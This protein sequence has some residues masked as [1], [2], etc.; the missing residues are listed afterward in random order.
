MNRGVGNCENGSGHIQ[1][2]QLEPSF[3]RWMNLSSSVSWEQVAC[4]LMNWGGQL[5]RALW[6]GG[7]PLPV[8]ISSTQRLSPTQSLTGK[9]TVGA[10]SRG[11][12]SQILERAFQGGIIWQPPHWTCFSTWRKNILSMFVFPDQNQPLTSRATSVVQKLHLCF[13][14]FFSFAR[15]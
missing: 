11:E 12:Q 8:S 7:L 5:L 13:L 2:L 1:L 4:F 14:L 6:Y 9:V 15:Y 3:W 10:A